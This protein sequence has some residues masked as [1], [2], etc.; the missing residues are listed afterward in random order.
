M[1]AEFLLTV[2]LCFWLLINFIV[3]RSVLLLAK[4]EKLLEDVDVIVDETFLE[5]KAEFTIWCSST[6]FTHEKDFLFHGALNAPPVMCASWWSPGTKTR[7]LIYV[8][9]TGTTYDFFTQLEGVVTVTTGSSKD[10]LTLPYAP[11]SFVQ[12]FTK[13]S[14]DGRF[15]RH[16]E[17]VSEVEGRLGVSRIAEGGELFHQIAESLRRQVIYIRDLP[18]WYLRG[19]YWFLV[20]RRLKVNKRVRQLYALR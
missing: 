16:C 9:Q 5:R 20:T 11:Q 10:A 2:P 1:S 3:Y 8:A 4:P 6:D 12:S 13:L 17:A 15:Q 14:H 18:F 19:T 7:A